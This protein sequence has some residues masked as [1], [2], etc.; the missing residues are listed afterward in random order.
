MTENTTKPTMETRG[1]DLVPDSDRY[2][3]PRDLFFLWAGTTTTV[4]TVVYGAGLVA[5]GLSFTQALIAIVLGNLLAYPLLGITSTTGPATG[6]TTMTISRQA[7]GVPGARVQGVFSWAMLVGFEAGGL[8]LIVYAALGL[9]N[10]FGVETNFTVQTITIIVMAAIQAILPLFGHAL[11]MKAQRYFTILFAAAFAMMAVLVLPQVDLA[12]GS[13]TV[14]GPAMMTVAIAY[15]MSAG[16]LSWA[17]SGANFSRYLPRNASRSQVALFAG[18]GG[19]LPYILLMTLG[20]AAAT[21]TLEVNDP[22]TGLP[23]VL[24]GWFALPYLL[25]VMVSLLV[26]NS[27]NLYSSGLNLQTAGVQVKRMTMVIV[28][29][30]VCAA[31]AFIAV[32]NESFYSLLGTFLGLIVLWLA[33]WV[34][35]F[36]AD[37]IMRRGR[38]ELGV[39]AGVN[40]SATTAQG[41]IAQGL[42]MAAA[43]LG[44]NGVFVGPL[45]TLAGGADLSIPLG[46]VVSFVAFMLLAKNRAVPASVSAATPTE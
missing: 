8:I 18:L 27:T 23:G 45:S 17:P 35:V 46:I 6:T 7:F 15:V 11:L 4:F 42:G 28:D 25:L 1:I 24:P 41:L 31:I 2:G 22:I 32:T 36:I 39:L 29:S 26:Q 33:P 16:G 3:K 44:L 30:I 10:S 37:L 12:T 9:L 21:I 43:A 19:A 5:M 20:A 38:Y 40:A 34:G 14:V 13:G